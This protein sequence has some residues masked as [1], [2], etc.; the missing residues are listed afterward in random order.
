MNSKGFSSVFSLIII[1]A[2]V[3]SGAAVSL[4][5]KNK[6]KANEL[7]IMKVEMSD[8]SPQSSE[9]LMG[10]VEPHSID[11][12][13]EREAEHTDGDGTS[14]IQEVG[15]SPENQPV[16]PSDQKQSIINNAL[17]PPTDPSRKL[18]DAAQSA[19][20]MN[21]ANGRGIALQA[22]TAGV[23]DLY[24]NRYE[25]A[26][27][28]ISLS[29]I[30]GLTVAYSALRNIPGSVLEVMRGKTIYFSTSSDRPYANLTGD[31]GGTLKNTKAGFILTQP[32]SEESTIHEFGHIVGYHGIEGLY[33][34]SSPFSDLKTDY[35]ALFDTGGIAYPPSATP[36][37]Y[38]SS[39]ATANKAENFAEH[40][41]YY[42]SKAGEFKLKAI[43]DDLLAKKYDFFNTKLFLPQE[44]R[45]TNCQSNTSPV[46]TSHITD[47]SKVNYIVP[48]PTMGAGPSLKPHSY[49]G[50]DGQKVPIFAPAD[51]TLKSG[52]HYI[53]GPYTVELQISCEVTIRFGHVTDPIDVIKNLLPAEPQPDSRT[54]GLKAI[55][56]KAGDLLGY[57][58]GTSKAGNWDFGVYNSATSNRYANDPDWNNSST[59]TTAVCPFD[60]FASDLKTLYY[61]RFNP[62]RLGG[63]P[64]HGA[65]FCQG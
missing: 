26:Q 60:Y 13:P 14:V 63:N 25:L 55:V 32:M 40:F 24:Y 59:Y 22:I 35:D 57:T 37:G 49:I 43:G 45:Q 47:I 44:K 33:G 29:K 27:H 39:Y 38:I 41:A 50:T 62:Q 21:W 51:A 53:D 15:L 30:P 11:K 9:P 1:I 56:F 12:T 8:V 34:F 42:V 20:F 2:V 16:I 10:E 23:D 28:N 19:E 58:T 64:P 17:E 36:K 18:P 5:A 3:I 54:Q 52:S 6:N 46:F 61:S 48:P 7:K 65:S 4:V 31:Y